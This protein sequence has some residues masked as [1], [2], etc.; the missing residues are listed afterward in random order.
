MQPFHSESEPVEYAGPDV[1]QQHVTSGHQP[2]QQG[3]TLVRLEVRG[4]R[5]L[6]PVTG[7]EVG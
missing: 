1:F 7:Q 2:G 5:L 6:V 4:D 3:F